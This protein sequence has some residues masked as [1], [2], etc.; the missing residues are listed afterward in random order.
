[1]LILTSKVGDGIIIRIRVTI[2]GIRIHRVITG[3]EA[4][5]ELPIFRQNIA[6]ARARGFQTW[7]FRWPRTMPSELA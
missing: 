4:P 7:P 6:P 2:Q 1:M 3:I 5:A